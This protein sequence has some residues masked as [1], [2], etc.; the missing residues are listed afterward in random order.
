M[1]NKK[2]MILTISEE[3]KWIHAI[4]RKANKTIIGMIMG[5]LEQKSMELKIPIP[6]KRL[7][8]YRY[9][10]DYKGKLGISGREKYMA[11]IEKELKES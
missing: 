9:R 2:H 11:K 7:I 10:R 5:F 8:R 4:S 3:Q 6:E 1:V